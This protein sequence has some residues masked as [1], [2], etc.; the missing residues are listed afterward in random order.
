MGFPSYYPIMGGF[1]DGFRIDIS[2]C[3]F[4]CSVFDFL[5]SFLRSD[6]FAFFF[7][8]PLYYLGLR[9]GD[10]HVTRPKKLIQ[11]WACLLPL[12]REKPEIGHGFAKYVGDSFS[13]SHLDVYSKSSTYGNDG[14]VDS[15][16]AIEFVVF[17]VLLN[18]DVISLSLM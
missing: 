13:H 2:R 11:I 15:W 16:L 8:S 5:I 14:G 17:V 10:D 4:G 1:G 9:L 6:H 3:R 12:V 7:F 18:S